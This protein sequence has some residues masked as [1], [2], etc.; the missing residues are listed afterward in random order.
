MRK[1][2]SAFFAIALVSAFSICEIANRV[3]TLAGFSKLL[4]F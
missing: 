4:H 1:E 3:G 2:A